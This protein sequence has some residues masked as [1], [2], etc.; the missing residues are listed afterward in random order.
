MSAV[1]YTLRLAEASDEPFLYELFAGTQGQQFYLLPLE[2]AIRDALI[3]MQFEA[4]RTSYLQQYPASEHFI[5]L[6]EEQPAGRLW[7]NE[8]AEEIN[9]IDIVLTPSYQGRGIGTELLQ[10]VIAKA[11]AAGKAVRLFVDR[12]NERAFE[13]YRGLG[14]EVCGE[15]P[16][17]LEM[18][19]APRQATQG[20]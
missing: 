13:L 9:V 3:R 18:R 4:Q 1:Q 2:P 14:F 10:Q 5:I 11:D 16:F 7:V 8:G 17:Y 15:V 6:V 19:R 12:T 20:T